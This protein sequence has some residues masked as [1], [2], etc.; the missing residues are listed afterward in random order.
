M[1]IY[2]A[3]QITGL[4]Y[5]DAVKKF[6]KAKQKLLKSAYA[7]GITLVVINPMELTN[8]KMSRAECMK[9]CIR[10]LL[11]CDAIYMLKGW[12][13]SLGAVLENDIAAQIGLK[14][15]NEL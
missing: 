4:P 8:E 10:E 7:K 15:R 5:R 14:I 1:K 3:G 12:W 13:L 6:A 2:I 9:I 11:N